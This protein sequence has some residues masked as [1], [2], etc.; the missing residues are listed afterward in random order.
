VD[1]AKVFMQASKSGSRPDSNLAGAVQVTTILLFPGRSKKY[2]VCARSGTASMKR[3]WFGEMKASLRGN[4]SNKDVGLLKFFARTST[5]LPQSMPGEQSLR[6]C[7][8][9]LKT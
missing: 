9:I 3:Y 4:F 7:L 5:G 1:D 6:K 8:V 2:T